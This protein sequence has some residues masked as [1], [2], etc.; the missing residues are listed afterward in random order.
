MSAAFSLPVFA[1]A[2]GGP[3]VKGQ[4]RRCPAD[5]QVDE[6]LGFEPDGQ[7]EHFLLHVRKTN[8]NTEWLARQLAKFVGIKP[9]DVSYAG[10][11]DRNAITT[12]WFSVRLPGNAE[13]DWQAFATQ[14]Y[15][16]LQAQRHSRKLRRGSLQGN[17]FNI[18]VTGLDG[19][20]ELLET[21]LQRIQQ[22]GVPNYFAEQRFGHGGDNLEMADKLLTAGQRIKNRHKRSLY[23]SAARSFL[24]NQVCAARVENHSWLTGLAGDA[25]MLAGSHS[26]FIAENIDTTIQQRLAQGDIMTTGPLWGRGQLP[27]QAQASALEEQ[28]LAP[29]AQWLQGLEQL[30]LK[31]ERRALCVKPHDMRWQIDTQQYCLQVEFTLP[32]GSYA[33]SVLREAINYS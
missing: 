32:A 29:Y 33:T 9:M 20:L 16:V 22:Q 1:F 30:G 28:V 19:D 25:M 7:G 12:Q 14:D 17:R 31:Q 4:I 21:R 5:F 11:K 13:P 8:T 18:R 2:H 15:Q 6:I 23:I 24:F 26:F 10:L 3:A 27:T